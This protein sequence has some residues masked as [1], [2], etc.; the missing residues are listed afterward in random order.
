[1][2]NGTSPPPPPGDTQ[3]PFDMLFITMFYTCHVTEVGCHMGEQ[4]RI[5]KSL[6]LY[7]V[8]N[9]NILKGNTYFDFQNVGFNIRPIFFL[10]TSNVC[11]L[12]PTIKFLKNIFL[13]LLMMYFTCYDVIARYR[14]E[15]T[16]REGKQ[17]S[18]T[19]HSRRKWIAE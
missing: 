3:L 14:R 10:D 5:R 19:N 12:I 13:F 4:L 8:L 1:M 7:I 18:K 16:I 17:S 2:V 6:K 15:P 9:K 11:P